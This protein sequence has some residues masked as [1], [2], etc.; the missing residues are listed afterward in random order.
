[1]ATAK[2]D[3]D[4]NFLDFETGC[5]LFK[6]FFNRSVLSCAR[7]ASLYAVLG[8]RTTDFLP[9]FFSFS[10]KC[11]GTQ[12]KELLLF[13][14]DF[15]ESPFSVCPEVPATSVSAFKQLF[16]PKNKVSNVITAVGSLRAKACS[17]CHIW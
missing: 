2:G 17:T 4:A 1:M 15:V 3:G 7:C 11:F 13:V 5:N 14:L 9:I 10:R 8:V 12:S 16:M 6:C